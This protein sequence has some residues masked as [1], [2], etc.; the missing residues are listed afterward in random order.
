MSLLLENNEHMFNYISSF[1]QKARSVCSI[2]LVYS[3]GSVNILEDVKL[4][5]F[6]ADNKF[7]LLKKAS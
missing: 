4:A 1:P 5:G 2:G 3:E 7:L 6:A